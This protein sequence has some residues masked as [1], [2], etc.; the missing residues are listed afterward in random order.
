MVKAIVITIN[1]KRGISMNRSHNNGEL[2]TS[3]I[4]KQVILVGWVARKRNL[5]GLVFI[6]LRDRYGIT[7]IVCRSELDSITTGIR[8]EYIL[9]VE[10][11]V[12]PR[13]SMNPNLKT[14]EIEVIAS[15]IQ[16]INV[17]ETPPMI[18]ADETDALEDLRMKYRYLDLRRP[19]MQ[20][21]LIERHKIVRSV[22]NYLEERDFV[23]VETPIL[24]RQTP[25]GARDYLVPSRVNEGKFYA[26]PQSPQLFKQL[27]MVSGLERYYQ[28]ARCFRDEDLR[29]DRQPD[30][31]QIDIETS[32][33]SEEDIY[34]LVEGLFATIL[35]D[36]KDINLSLPFPRYSYHEVMNRFGSDK[37][38]TRFGYELADV[39]NLLC[40]N[41]FPLIADAITKEGSVKAIHLPGKAK[42]LSRKEL[43]T[44]N[45]LAK[46]HRTKGLFFAR[47]F[48]QDEW[49]GS[50]TKYLSDADKTG[51]M[52]QFQLVPNDLLI[53]VADPIW[54]R[55]CNALG[56][57]RL[58]LGKKYESSSFTGYDFLWVVDFPL[59]EHD[60]EMNT[61][62]STHH[63]FTR[64][65]DEDLPLLDTNPALVRA[66]HYDLVLNG[67]ELGSGSL[68]IYDQQVQRKV[69]EI[70]GL[71][72]EEIEHKFGF[73]INA[74]RYGTPPHGGVAF[75]LDRI[76]MILTNSESIRDVIAF[77][78]NASAVCPLTEAP[79]NI[80]DKLLAE[81]HISLRNQK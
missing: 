31:T 3:D 54:E 46:K 36:V 34:S 58:V 77:P 80:D 20:Q 1:T 24:T 48:G 69:F 72:Q 30:F 66:H 68:R 76:A 64:P 9:Q 14:G 73:F 21:K 51:L 50:F 55:V 63:P 6:D 22:R 23:E 25:E 10:G 29:S 45:E 19:I 74:F 62:S 65:Y 61:Y 40:Q 35:K 27:L 38:D 5:G 33:F 16:I 12:A 70:I 59:F 44:L 17:S 37:P 15:A 4:G 43:D 57:I 18:I 32:F 2:R 53:F 60:P 56:A 28:I 8:N 81:L 11:Q 47:F 39:S 7:Q 49:E 41:S 42:E 75:G 71:S 67:S 52:E 13:E 26:L 78:K 79:S